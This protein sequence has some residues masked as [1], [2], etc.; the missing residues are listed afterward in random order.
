MITS[1]G[2]FKRGI[3]SFMKKKQRSVTGY[4]LEWLRSSSVERSSTLPNMS[5]WRGG[6]SERDCCF[7]FQNSVVVAVGKWVLGL[8]DLWPDLLF[9]RW[10]YPKTLSGTHASSKKTSWDSC[11]FFAR[12]ATGQNSGRLR[13]M[14]KSSLKIT[15]FLSCFIINLI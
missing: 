13:R 2:L 8:V 4:L 9:F 5:C 11:S 12:M 10:L 6:S 1:L 15:S 14:Y 3:D 7:H